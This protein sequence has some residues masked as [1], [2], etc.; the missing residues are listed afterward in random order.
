MP[1]LF[2]DYDQGAGG[3]YFCAELSKS[4]E[5]VPLDVRRVNNGRTKVSDVFQQEF[6]KPN[7]TIRIVDVISDR[8][9]VVPTHQHTK[10][11]HEQLGEIKSIRIAYPI[12]ET[13]RLFLKTQQINKVI[14]STEPT[15]A[16]FVGLVKIL[17][18][19]SVNPDF[20]KKIKFG[21]D[22]LS[23]ILLSKGIDPTQESKNK[24]LEEL[25]QAVP[26]E[27]NFDYDLIIPYENLF[28]CPDLVKSQLQKIFNITIT[29][30]WLHSFRLQYDEYTKT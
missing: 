3:E 21:M 17:S 23:L 19:S 9:T 24:F 1:F 16:E 6:L 30:N 8:Y 14:L 22:N 26:E 20:L 13:Y 25:K 11:A 15:S 28:K 29:D 2:V 27:P 10:L 7:P 18:R 12:E 5:C 4:P